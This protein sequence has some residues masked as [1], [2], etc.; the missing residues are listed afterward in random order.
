MIK[1]TSRAKLGREVKEILASGSILSSELI[2]QLLKDKLT[3][4]PLE[5]GWIIVGFPTSLGKLIDSFRSLTVLLM[6]IFSEQLNV[7]EEQVSPIQRIIHFEISDE[8]VIRLN[9]TTEKPDPSIEKVLI[10]YGNNWERMKQ[11][12]MNKTFNSEKIMSIPSTTE[13]EELKEIIQA[14][15]D[16]VTHDKIM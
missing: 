6:A 3:S 13:A 16:E 1:D 8:E 15:Q 4:I 5:K 11:H 2:S 14:I 12:V 10:Q 7:F 9:S